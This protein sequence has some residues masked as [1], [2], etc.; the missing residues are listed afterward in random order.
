[1]GSLAKG[2]FYWKRPEQNSITK[3]NAYP[4]SRIDDML[5]AIGQSN[6]ITTLDLVKTMIKRRL[7]FQVL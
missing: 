6:F 2:P 5:D 3:F 4:M 1:M 7:H